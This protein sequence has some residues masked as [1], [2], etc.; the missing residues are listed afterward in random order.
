MQSASFTWAN[1]FTGPDVQAVLLLSVQV[2]LLEALLYSLPVCRLFFFGE[3]SC[4]RV[5]L[6]VTLKQPRT[7]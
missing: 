3:D 4:L 2:Q 6:C 7:H 5:F 1:D